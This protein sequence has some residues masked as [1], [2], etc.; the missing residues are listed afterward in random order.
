MDSP[1]NGISIDATSWPIVT[2]I[3]RG[4]ISDDEFERLFVEV[5]KYWRRGDRFLTIT[6]TRGASNASARQRQR[7]GEWMKEN[8]ASIQQTSIGSIV[9]LQSVIARGALTAINWIAQ[10]ELPSEYA[11]DWVQ[12]S[13]MATRML[14]RHDMLTDKLRRALQRLA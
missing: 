8:Q 6:D 1:P 13:E 3:L 11:K 5:E 4:A 7:I 12:A 9:I 14:D 10:P 2:F